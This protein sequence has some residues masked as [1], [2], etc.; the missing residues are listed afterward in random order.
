MKRSVFIR[1]IGMA[2][3]ALTVLPAFSLS[4]KQEKFTENMLTGKGNPRLIGN[5]FQLMDDAMEAFLEMKSAASEQGIT[6]Q[7]VSA[8]RNYERQLQIWNR[9]YN[10]FV[11][12]GLSPL[13]AM[14]KIVEYSTFPG[15]SRH[16]WGT[17]ID[18]IQTVASSPADP[19]H[20]KHFA[21]GGKFY[22][23]KQWLNDNAEKF[24]FYE[25]Y[26]NDSQRKGFYYEPWHF[27]YKP[28]SV[29]MLMAF[30]ELDLK[31][32]FQNPEVAGCEYI[33]EKFIEEYRKYHILDI[34]KQL[35]Q[36]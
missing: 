25:A 23:L 14:Q 27:S 32:L 12:S 31:K 15:T 2:A 30:L 20:A 24:G 9:K 1:N 33:T 34:H 6:I 22:R 19:L 26:T 3:A 11:K 8:Y 18:I 17:D 35:L 29:P 4:R 16:H 28:L 10:Q 7:M 36:K 5:D 13:D 21:E